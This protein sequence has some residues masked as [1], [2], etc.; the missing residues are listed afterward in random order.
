[1]PHFQISVPMDEQEY[2]A[3]IKMAQQ[4]YRHPRGQMRYLLREEAFRRHLIWTS[5]NEQKSD[6]ENDS[7]GEEIDG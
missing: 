1:M 4:D 3:L 2:Q 5:Q 6:N 7:S